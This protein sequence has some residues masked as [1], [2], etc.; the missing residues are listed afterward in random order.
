MSENSAVIEARRALSAMYLMV[1]EAVALDVNRKVQAAFASLT[2]PTPAVGAAGEA[3]AWWC[4]FK[5][6]KMT[7]ATTEAQRVEDWRRYGRT[8]R[9]LVFGDIAHPSAGAVTEEMVEAAARVLWKDAN[10]TFGSLPD[11][12]KDHTRNNA[13]EI[14]TA[15]LTRPT[16]EG[17]ED[18]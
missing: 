1:P 5:D 14:L 4:Q 10:V 2:L 17:R 8:V 3:V 7:D 9:P 6:S 12:V 16:S 11:Y 18:V 13:R 15:A